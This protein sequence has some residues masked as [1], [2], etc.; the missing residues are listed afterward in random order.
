MS[1]IAGEGGDIEFSGS[2]LGLL[3]PVR[4]WWIWHGVGRSGKGKVL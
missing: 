2:G 3:V 1:D 4:V